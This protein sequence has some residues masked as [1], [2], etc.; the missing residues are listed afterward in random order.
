MRKNLILGLLIFSLSFVLPGCDGTGGSS[1]DILLEGIIS[2]SAQ[3]G[4]ITVTI[5]QD[6]TRL[7]KTKVSSE[8]NFGILFNSSTGVVTLRFESST[9]NAE[10]PNIQVVDQSVTNLNITL[11]LNPTLIIIDRWQVF[12]DPISLRESNEIQYNESQA[13]FNLDA[14]GGN[15]IFATGTSL[16]SYRVK[17]INITNCREG[18]RAQTSASII[19]EADE[20]IVIS[21]NRDAI[22][23]IDDALVEVGQTSNP[24]NNTIVIESANQFGINASGNSVV[25]IDPQNQCSISGGRRALNINGN[26]S[27]D[28]SSCT[29][30]DG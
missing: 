17:S 29:L 20:S 14:D 7:G 13:E 10:R 9:F 15:C 23:A 11:Q 8:G 21:S 24:V 26:A 4:E 22:V 19:L 18:V 3:F 5:L 6:N 25:D 12:Q 28:T 27:V 30:S 1:G 2:N 16:I